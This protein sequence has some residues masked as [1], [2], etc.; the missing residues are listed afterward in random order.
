MRPNRQ[1]ETRCWLPRDHKAPLARG[2]E[3][4]GGRHLEARTETHGADIQPEVFRS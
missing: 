1:D 3:T 4:L 2:I